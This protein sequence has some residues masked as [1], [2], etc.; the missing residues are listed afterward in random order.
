MG[1][2]SGDPDLLPALR[3]S[4]SKRAPKQRGIASKKSRGDALERRGAEVLLSDV[5]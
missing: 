5:F 1:L 4:E 3:I 2:G